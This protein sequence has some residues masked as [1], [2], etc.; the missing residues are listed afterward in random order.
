MASTLL[1]VLAGVLLYSVVATALSAQGLLPE[2]VRVSGPITTLHTERGKAVLDRLARPK[3][4]W[5]AWANVGVGITLV[6]MVGS[7]VLVIF[8][9]VTI[10]DRPSST[11]I[12]EPQDALVIPGVNQFLP[13]SVAPEIVLG[14]LVGL[15]VHEGGH[16][17]LCRV[18]DISIASMGLALITLIPMG[19]F[20]EPDE[21]EQRTAE[22]GAQTRM[23]AA[24]VTNNFAITVVAFALLFGP[25]VGSIAVTPGVPVGGALPGTPA[26]QA[27]I[28]EGSVI[29][30]VA[31]QNVTNESDLDGALADASRTVRVSLSDGTTTTVERSPVVTGAVQNGPTG[32]GTGATIAAVNGSPVATESGFEAALENHTVATLRT[33]NGSTTAPMGAYASRVTPDGP[34]ANATGQ[35]GQPV[36]VTRFAGE[37]TTNTSAL[38]A[39]LSETNPGDEVQVEAFVDGERTTTRVT[40][41]ENPQTGSGLVGVTGLQQGT[42]G[43]VVDDFGIDAYPAAGYLAALGGS[44][45]A[46]GGGSALFGV[47]AVLTLPFASVAVPGASYNFAGFVGSNLGY[48]TV[49][50]PLEFLGGGVFV[51]ANVLFWVG[52]VNL[53]LGFFNCIPAFPL[54]GGHILRTSTEAVV[55]RLPVGSRRS[56][57]GAVTTAVSLTM[58]AALVLMVFGPSLLSG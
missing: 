7:F 14:L 56:L 29:T 33:E 28:G 4:F 21:E 15:V 36:V 11:V 19:A 39:A 2:W 38:S 25:V 51:L 10:L 16:G 34:L 20:V 9:A 52:W 12:T 1:W 24:G 45:G 35:A 41:G 23:F 47:L 44:G 37:R 30:G 31:G 53:N 48:Y 13:L 18:E 6:V 26:A 32:L 43:I 42:T 17:L 54:D 46:G 3:R 8:S 57:T 55:S 40:L 50:G 49:T 58:L 27:G 22:R 5:R